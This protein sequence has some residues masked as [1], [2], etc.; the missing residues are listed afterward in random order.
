MG[1][2]A[3]KQIPLIRKRS[4]GEYCKGG[5]PPEFGKARTAKVWLSRNQLVL[6]LTK[7]DN[8]AQELKSNQVEYG[9]FLQRASPSTLE[10]IEYDL[11]CPTEIYD[12][13]EFL[14]TCEELRDAK[15]PEIHPYLQ[16][17]GLV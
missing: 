4:T 15:Y 1:E 8:A 14:D 3:V 11:I 6:Y 13:R 12:L 17:K 5:C 9:K 7:L 2:L 16:R 10:V